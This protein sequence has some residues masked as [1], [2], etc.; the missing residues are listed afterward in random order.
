VTEPGEVERLLARI[1]FVRGL[2]GLLLLA[3]IGVAAVVAGGLAGWLL[4][5]AFVVVAVVLFVAL[6]RRPS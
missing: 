5:A 3:A 6:V 4:G 2:G 1:D